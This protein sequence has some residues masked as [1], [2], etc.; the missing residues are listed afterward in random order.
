MGRWL[1]TGSLL[2]TLRATVLVAFQPAHIFSSHAP[3]APVVTPRTCN[4]CDDNDC[5]LFRQRIC[6]KQIALFSSPTKEES[7]IRKAKRKRRRNSR[8]RSSSGDPRRKFKSSSNKKGNEA[9][10]LRWMDARLEETPVGELPPKVI[11]QMR[12]IMHV[13]AKQRSTK[14]AE[15]ANR[16]MTRLIKESEAGNADA[17]LST[18]IC[19]TCLSAWAKR[20]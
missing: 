8:T 2:I 17:K 4:D 15:N 13:Y 7:E 12:P 1:V 3:C 16:L 9:S 10:W 14:S 18:K 5:S 11:K 19:N 6:T 20:W